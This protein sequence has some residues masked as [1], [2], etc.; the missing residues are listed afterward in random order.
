M[1]GRQRG[2]GGVDAGMERER[3]GESRVGWNSEPEMNEED[4]RGSRRGK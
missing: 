1:E 3:A 2:R 4:E